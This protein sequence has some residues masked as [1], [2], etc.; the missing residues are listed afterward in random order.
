MKLSVVIPAYNEAERIAQT[1]RE[2]L[3]YFDRSARPVEVLLV[4]DGSTDSTVERTLEA[5][6]GDKRIKV[7]KCPENKGKGAA[8]RTGILASTGSRVL[9]SDADLS[10]PLSELSILEE[11]LD[12]GIQ[13]AIG[14]RGTKGAQLVR[15]QPA[16][17]ELAG[18]AGNLVIGLV[19]PPLWGISDTQCGFKL[20][21]GA[22]ARKLFAMQLLERFGFDVEILYLARRSGYTVEEIPVVWAHNTG[23]KVRAVDYVYTMIEVLK[24][25]IN[26]LSGK[27]R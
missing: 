24:V 22:I 2:T 19:C 16:L 21:E 20:F 17:R 11:R 4:D 26:D 12:A 27:Y 15:R 23:S 5:A 3:S 25:R 10:T 6:A 14:S 1:I 18:K 7:I 9:L 8:V 13:I